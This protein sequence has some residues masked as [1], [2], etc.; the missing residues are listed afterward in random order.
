V[1]FA[2]W[3]Q[4]SPADAAREFRRRAGTLLPPAQRRAVFA[5]LPSPETLESAFDSAPPGSPLRG[6][7][8]LLKDLFDVA[9]LPTFAGSTFLPEIRPAPSRD[10][11]I[12]RDLRAAGAVFAGQTHLHE[13]AWGLTGENPHYGDCEHPRFPGRTSG[14]SSSGSAAAVAADVVPFAVGTDTGGSI[15]APAAFCGVYGFRGVPHHPWIADAFPLA[16]SFDTAGFFARTA[17][18]LRI[19]LEALLAPVARPPSDRP[20]RGGY[21]ALPG[22]DPEVAAACAAAAAS[23]APPAD[24][25]TAGEL[26]HRFAPAA[27]LYGV[28]GG[29]ESAAVHAPW[30]DRYRDRYDPSVWQRCERARSL[31]PAQVAAAEAQVASLRDAWQHYF[32]THDFAVLPAV[33]FPA[34]TKADCTPGNRARM[35]SLTAPVSLAG[36]PALCL[37]VPLPSGL[38][39]GLQVVVKDL[40]SPAIAWALDPASLTI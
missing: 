7:P 36:L 24:A 38:S 11:A 3:Q 39:A 26:R 25:E 18:D 21:L 9:G 10:G 17:R 23:L 15:R 22:V 31:S 32:K 34:L 13:F 28:L 29:S 8:Y 6:V 30:A 4:L 2:D 37:P 5:H 33:P 16:P 20:L 1:T 14:G 40:E 19:A 12:V 27:E 35:L